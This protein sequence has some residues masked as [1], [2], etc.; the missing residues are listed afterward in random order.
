MGG[1]PQLSGAQLVALLDRM[2]QRPYYAKDPNGWADV[3]GEW[4]GPDAIW[5]R[6]EWA[7]A[8]AKG[9]ANAK[10]DPSLL[11]EE[12]L[13]PSLTPNTARAIKLA[14]SP[15]QGLALFLTA[16]EFQRR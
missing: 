12:A 6:V 11:A 7:D 13:G 3:E 10:V 1:Q 5:K 9:M 8:L 4:I 14:E 2:G 16:P 15:A